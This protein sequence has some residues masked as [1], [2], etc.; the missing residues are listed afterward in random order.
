MPKKICKIIVPG[1]L[2]EALSFV[3]SLLTDYGLKLK[4]PASGK[5][6]F[7][8]EEGDQ[9]FIKDGNFF[10]EIIDGGIKN[11]QFWADAS[12][13]FFVSWV[14]IKN[15]LEVNINFGS[16]RIDED[17]EFVS[18]LLRQYLIKYPKKTDNELFSLTWW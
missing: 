2:K 12:V 4:N 16:S 3:F 11:I 15:E 5:I 8:N 13:D 18:Y 6:S 14:E 1:E 7:W 10:N 9:L 17:V